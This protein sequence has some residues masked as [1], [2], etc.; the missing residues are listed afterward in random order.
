MTERGFAKL[1][2]ITILR[3][4]NGQTQTFHFS[5]VL[6]SQGVISNSN[7]QLFHTCNLEKNTSGLLRHH[8][9]QLHEWPFDAQEITY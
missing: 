2:V 9:R 3:N 6:T 4:M 8:H 5:R 7:G 1:C